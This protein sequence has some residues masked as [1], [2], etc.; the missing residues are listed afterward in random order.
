MRPA[1]SA[2]LLSACAHAQA[3]RECPAGYVTEARAS[4]ELRDALRADPEG[5]RLLEAT[6]GRAT[7]CFARGGPGVLTEGALLLD[8]A[9][10]DPRVVARAAHLLHHLARGE[11]VTSGD[12][13][14]A[15]ERAASELEARVFARACQRSASPPAYC[16][17][18]P[19]P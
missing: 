1:W 15:D 7:F 14:S 6:A 8:D 2:L 18:V 9:P 3:P 19:P 17:Q 10:A 16:T 12:P 13:H 4:T 11:R 5:A